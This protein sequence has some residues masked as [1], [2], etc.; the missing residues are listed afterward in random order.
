MLSAAL[1]ADIVAACATHEKNNEQ[2]PYYTRAFRFQD[3]FIKFGEYTTFDSEAMTLKYLADLAAQDPEAP[4][5]PRVH[6]YFYEHGGMAY[7]V[8]EYIPLVEVPFEVR[9]KAAAQAVLWMRSI[10]VPEDVVLGPKGGGPAYHVVF[11]T[12]KAPRCYT[13]IRAL[14][15]FLNKVRSHP[16]L[17]Y[18]QHWNF[19]LGPWYSPR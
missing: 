8:M 7:V 9:A 3:Y 18:F 6:H 4:R 2:D 1:R 15:R 17:C 19:S 12:A 16:L 10:P 13:S 5:V 14:E 11:K